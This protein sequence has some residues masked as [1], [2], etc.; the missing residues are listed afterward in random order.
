MSTFHCS[1][2]GGQISIPPGYASPSLECGHCRRPS[3][4]P[5][6]LL[7][8]APGTRINTSHALDYAESATFPLRHPDWFHRIWWLAVVNF[9]PVL[10]LV[11][12]RGWR[13][14]LTRRIGYGNPQPFPESR[15]LG[16]FLG[17]GVILWFMTFLYNVPLFFVIFFFERELPRTLW[18]TVVFLFQWI[19]GEEGASAGAFLSLLVKALGQAS[20]PTLCYFVAWP[21]YRV[22]ML[23]FALTGNPGSFFRPIANLRLVLRH[24]NLFFLLFFFDLLSQT[25]LAVAGGVLTAL[26]IG[27]LVTPAVLLP[28][29]YWTTGHLY[30]RAAS[31]LAYELTGFQAPSLPQAGAGQA[32]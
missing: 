31:V 29:Y 23:R 14:E 27:V 3:P 7:P 10:N 15:D 16:N 2:C 18:Q 13:L 17:S 30:G 32:A 5:V 28:M 22:A 9:V 19:W 4:I 26:G 21:L 12:M 1:F 8:S 25:L 24:L 20:L 6:S 11:L